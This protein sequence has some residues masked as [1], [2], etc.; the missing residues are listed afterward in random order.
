MRSIKDFKLEDWEKDKT[1]KVVCGYG[2]PVDII[3]TDFSHRTDGKEYPILAVIH[4]Q[5]EGYENDYTHFYDVDGLYDPENK[6]HYISEHNLK[7]VV[8]EPELTEFEEKVREL[9]EFVCAHPSV[10]GNNKQIKELARKLNFSPTFD[11]NGDLNLIS[12]YSKGLLDGES[13]TMAK[14]PYW[15]K[16]NNPL[17]CVNDSDK[18]AFIGKTLYHNGYFINLND[19]WEKLEKG[20]IN[21]KKY[22]A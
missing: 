10:K 12:I 8:E 3:G 16:I 15:V 13:E 6:Q 21:D 22:Y 5:T 2:W 18:F 17:L 14:M 20:K 9:I 7:I 11:S 19:L 4:N 1:Q